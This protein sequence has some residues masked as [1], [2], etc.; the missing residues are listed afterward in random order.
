MA[1]ENGQRLKQ[2]LLFLFLALSILLIAGAWVEGFQE[3]NAAPPDQG[4][5]GRVPTAV[6]DEYEEM[7]PE[8]TGTRRHEPEHGRPTL[9]PD[10]PPGTPSRDVS[11]EEM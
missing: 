1:K 3:L 7:T 11:G 2:I 4:P 5:E 10:A 6:Y 9:T 8:P